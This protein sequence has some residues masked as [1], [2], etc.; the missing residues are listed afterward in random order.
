MTSINKNHFYTYFRIKKGDYPSLNVLINYILYQTN[1]Q[2][3]ERTMNRILLGLREEMLIDVEYSSIKKGYHINTDSTPK[4]RIE[5]IDMLT[6]SFLN[7]N[8]LETVNE[9][10]GVSD[11]IEFDYNIS[12]VKYEIIAKALEAIKNNKKVS[13]IYKKFNESQEKRID[14][15]EIHLIKEYDRRWYIIGTF[16]NNQTYYPFGVDRILELTI[17]DKKYKPIKKV[18]E[19]YN[20]TEGILIIEDKE[21][22]EIEFDVIKRFSEYIE[23][24]PFH[25]SQKLIKENNLTKTY[26][27]QVI[28]SFELDR[29]FLKNIDWITDIKPKSY[30]KRIKKIIKQIVL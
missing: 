18:R 12:F 27:L 2:V 1:S 8:L 19:Y 11:F 20:A 13:F 3:S 7:K 4:D 9:W 16:E 28:P 23:T 25:H 29:K 15:L 22:I 5:Y 6:D 24:V 30:K 26:S 10:K 14:E 17:T 21:T